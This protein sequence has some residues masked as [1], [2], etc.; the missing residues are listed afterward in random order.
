MGFGISADVRLMPDAVPMC[1][2]LCRRV[3]RFAA[4]CL[5]L[6]TLGRV[7]RARSAYS[8]AALSHHA[9][10]ID[11]APLVIAARPFDE[12]ALVVGERH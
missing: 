2:R 4:L 8:A 5:R 1:N 7:G 10:E 12:G 11:S 6:Q 9:P 3:C